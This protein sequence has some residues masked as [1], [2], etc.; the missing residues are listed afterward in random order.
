MN[1]L[2]YSTNLRH[3]GQATLEL[4]LVLPIFLFLLLGV[5]EVALLFYYNVS[6][7][8]A[9]R[10]AARYAASSGCPSSTACLDADV[11]YY[12]DCTGIKN[13]AISK[14]P[15]IGLTAA[16]ISITYDHGPNNSGVISPIADVCSPT[17][18]NLVTGDRV[19]VTVTKQ[20][21]FIVP[22]P[23]FKNFPIVS[24]T[25]RTFLGKVQ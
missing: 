4:A 14:A 19:V 9:S 16:N 25:Y 18:P 15:G 8:N 6:V 13:R 24:T 3:K 10:E 21:T 7:S 2:F 11:Q 22:I 20:F 5:F 1:V 12:Q 17:T 23:G